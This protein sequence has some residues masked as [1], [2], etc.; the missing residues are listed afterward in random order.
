MDPKICDVA[1]RSA[2][3]DSKNR[4]Y[5]RLLVNSMS[6]VLSDSS[7][8]IKKT[9]SPLV[10]SKLMISTIGTEMPPQ[11]KWEICYIFRFPGIL[12]EIY[13][14]ELEAES[15]NEGPIQVM[16]IPP[17]VSRV[18]V[19]F[20]GGA[21][22]ASSDLIHNYLPWTTDTCFEPLPKGRFFWKGWKVL[23]R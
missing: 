4:Y 15:W 22:H 9:P 2:L 18:H 3:M 7:H 5:P 1:T 19:Y 10:I 16:I 20:L 21:T 12:A 23:S 17:V 8:I 13:L 11:T 6:R 14:Y